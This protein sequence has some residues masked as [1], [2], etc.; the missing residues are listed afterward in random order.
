MVYRRV[1]LLQVHSARTNLL[2][3]RAKTINKRLERVEKETLEKAAKRKKEKFLKKVVFSLTRLLG[4]VKI[5]DCDILQMTTR[6]RLGGG[7]FKD[8]EDPFLLQVRACFL[9]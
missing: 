9:S 8:C 3:F 1:N 6:Q 4:S 7:E 5:L 2:H